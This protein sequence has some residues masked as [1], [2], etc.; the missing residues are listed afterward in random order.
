MARLVVLS[1]LATLTLAAVSALPARAASM[2]LSCQTING[3]TICVRGSGANTASS[4]SC[5][6]MNGHTECVGSN[7]GGL[8]CETINGR[9]TCRGG[10]GSNVQIFRPNFQLDVPP[11]TDDDDDED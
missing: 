4:L 2:S 7:S 5:W 3:Q 1:A 6:T 11:V 9:L 10:Y 8:R